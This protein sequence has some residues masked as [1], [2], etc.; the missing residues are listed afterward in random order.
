MPEPEA[1]AM[2]KADQETVETSILDRLTG[3]E[4]QRPLSVTEIARDFDSRITTEDA[5][6]NLQADGLIHRC[7]ELIFPTRAAVRAAQIRW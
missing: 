7:G 1:T 4:Q 5:L 3:D 6:R 2:P